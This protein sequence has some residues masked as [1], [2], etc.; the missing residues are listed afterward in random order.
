LKA[1]KE[2]R[3][4]QEDKKNDRK[5]PPYKHIKVR[6][7]GGGQ[8]QKRSHKMSVQVI[9]RYTE[10]LLLLGHLAAFG[11]Y[12]GPIGTFGR[13]PQKGFMYAQSYMEAGHQ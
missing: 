13:P 4:L 1:Q 2:L 12:F 11:G 7:G 9:Y 8:V 3:Q 6:A 10:T 5:P